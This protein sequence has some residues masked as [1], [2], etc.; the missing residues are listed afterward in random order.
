MWITTRQAFVGVLIAGVAGAVLFPFAIYFIGLALAP[1]RPIPATTHVPPL[2]AAAIWARADGDGD[3]LRPL[4]PVSVAKFAAC[5]AYED[6]QDTTPGDA[7]RVAACRRYMPA[8]QGLEYL[9]TMHMRE[10]HLT[11]SFREG[12]G[13]FST[14]VWMTRSWTKV[15]FIDTVAER[16]EFGVRFRGLEAA[17]QG[18]FARDAAHL[19]LPQAALAASFVGDRRD[20]DPWCDPELAAGRR[21]R[22]LVRMRE[23]Q[24]IDEAAFQS[25]DR[26]ELGLGPPPANHTSCAG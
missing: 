19:T 9:S 20:L 15:E 1:P 16:G 4:S 17:A 25:A 7:R 14:T 8:I 22:I 12:L 3:A 23:N 2:V 5:I 26:S 24:A 21:H 6:F 13:R 10:A 11:P 18:Y